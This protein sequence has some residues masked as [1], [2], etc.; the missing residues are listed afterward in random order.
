MMMKRGN[1]VDGSGIKKTK[2][3]NDGTNVTGIFLGGYRKF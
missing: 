3:Y 1:S 2:N